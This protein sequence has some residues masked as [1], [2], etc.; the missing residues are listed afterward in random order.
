M[1]LHCDLDD[2]KITFLQETG[3]R[4]CITIIVENIL[5]RQIFNEILNLRCDLDCKHGKAIFSQ[6]SPAD[7][8][9]PSNNYNNIHGY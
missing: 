9:V 6:D 8:D 3:A 7:D 2:G 4:C 1:S 5:S